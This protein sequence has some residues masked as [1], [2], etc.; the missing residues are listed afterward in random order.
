MPKKLPPQK[1]SI[2]KKTENYVR[3][4]SE[5]R[6]NKSKKTLKP[7]RLNNNYCFR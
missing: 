5:K 7:T 1:N 6:A 2:Q 4:I 3:K